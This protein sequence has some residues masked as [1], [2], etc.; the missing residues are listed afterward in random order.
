MLLR[1]GA[2]SST[3]ILFRFDRRFDKT[4]LSYSAFNMVTFGDLS[5]FFIIQLCEAKGFMCEICG[6][7]EVIFAFDPHAAQC[8]EC[9]AVF[10]K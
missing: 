5:Y 6:K 3:C 7:D 2:G 4:A 1:R 8:N 10:H 9:R